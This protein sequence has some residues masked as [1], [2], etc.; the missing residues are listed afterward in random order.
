MQIDVI[1]MQ[2]V[3]KLGQMGDVVRVKS[4][5]A[6]N[7]LIP[8]KKA[9]RATPENRAQFDERRAQIEANNLESRQEAEGLVGKVENRQVVI[10]RQASESGQ[11][12]G[13]VSPKD[14]AEALSQDGFSISRHQVNLAERIKTL[15]VFVAEIQLHPEVST[16]VNLNV[17]KSD[18]EAEMQW[19]RYERGEP[20]LMTAAEEEA[21]EEKRAQ[22]ARMKRDEEKSL[23]AA[24]AAQ[25]QAEA[26]AAASESGADSTGHD[27]ATAE[28]A[29]DKS[30]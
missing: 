19:G 22:E 29:P 12:Y 7:Y 25:A 4:G 26:E 15:G 11:L 5:Y 28:V 14:I 6:R 1:L 18:G 27:S 24:E 21:L 17:A 23:A 3:P 13:S 2:R 16:T 9:L 20:V 8:Q 30:Q 10:L